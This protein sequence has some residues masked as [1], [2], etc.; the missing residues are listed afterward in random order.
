MTGLTISPSRFDFSDARRALDAHVDNA[1][2]PGVLSALL[3]GR[4]LVD[5]HCAGFA[6]REQ[7]VPMRP[8]HLFRI[9]SNTKLVTTCAAL[10]LVEAG[11]LDLDAPVS[12]H[13]PQLADRRV[14]R[15]GARTIDDTEPARSE[16]TL[17]HL[18]T[19]SAGLTYGL[20]DPGTPISRAYGA[21]RIMSPELTLAEMVD[22]LAPL[23]LTYHPGA[24]W[25]YSIAIDV[26]A[27][28]IEVVT[29]ERFDTFVS[30][31]IF[32]PLGMRETGFVVPAGEHARLAAYY[33]GADLRAPLAPGLT[34]AENSPYPGAFLRPVARLNAGGGLVSSL[35]D[36]IALV[37]SLLPDGPTLLAPDTIAMMMR[38]Q[39]PEGVWLKFPGFGEYLGMGFGLGGAVT[40]TTAHGESP[41][42]L[43][44][45]QWGG[46]A[47]THWWIAPRANLAGLLMTQRQM[48]FW[49][50][51]FFEFK[52]HVYAAIER[53]G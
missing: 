34:R 46:I 8:D 12:R 6:D 52:R 38:N 1:V 7:K 40:H 33:A 26:A 35:S 41:L 39:L 23:P 27:R 37:R 49:H 22:A 47:G 5:L 44:E 18:L 50:P 17:R 48:A 16:I 25:E 29:G 13:L 30:R 28:L 31:R 4:D 32:E 20:F 53:A 3:V 42:A 2:L 36:M 14:L 15:P 11:E 10:L 51:Y 45:F 21:A 43:G 19:H 24:G 9:F